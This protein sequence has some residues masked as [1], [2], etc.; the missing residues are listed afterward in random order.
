MARLP[1]AWMPIPYFASVR[2]AGLR[3]QKGQ[4]SAAVLMMRPA[5]LRPY[6]LERQLMQ[7]RWRQP[8]RPQAGF[9][10]VG[11]KLE[12]QREQGA[13]SVWRREMKPCRVEMSDVG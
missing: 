13:L 9:S 10:E 2:A 7:M 5:A 6:Q 3:R 11:R 4:D 8:W 1:T 12:K